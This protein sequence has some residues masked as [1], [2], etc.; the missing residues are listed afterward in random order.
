VPRC[1]ISYE[2]R[3]GRCAWCW[4]ELPTAESHT[5]I[6]ALSPPLLVLHLHHACFDTYRYTS[7]LD[8]AAASSS[9]DWPPERIERLRITLGW[10]LRRHRNP[11]QPREDG[12][13]ARQAETRGRLVGY[14][15]MVRS[16]LDR[17]RTRIGTVIY[18]TRALASHL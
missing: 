17:D 11:S 15:L 12:W 13:M 3:W 16:C 2:T 5:V 14:S 4:G 9:K 6:T 18:S 10:D 8:L 7:G 1:E